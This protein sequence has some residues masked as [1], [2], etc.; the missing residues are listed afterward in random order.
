MPEL[1]QFNLLVVR[2]DIQQYYLVPPPNHDRGSLKR[3]I[4]RAYHTARTLIDLALKLDT[5]QGFLRHVP[6][7]VFRSLLDASNIIIFVL[8]SIYT[9]EL[10]MVSGEQDVKKAIVCLRRTAVQE[11]D[12]SVRSANILEGFWTFRH[13]IPAVGVG[14]SKFP[15]R[16]GAVVTFDCLRRWRANLADA[17]KAQEQNGE[18]SGESPAQQAYLITNCI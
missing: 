1:D 17:K 2:L 5:A 11:G 3:N 6:H 7:W 4:I 10:D 13:I 16:I 9:T 14:M 18:V 15:H 12:L 8:H